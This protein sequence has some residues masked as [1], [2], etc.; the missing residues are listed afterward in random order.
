[1]KA[2]QGEF[3]PAAWA[4]ITGK[5]SDLV[6]LDF[7]GA[8]GK[9]TLKKLRLDPHVQTPSGGYHAYFKHPGFRVA[10]LNFKSK[11]DLGKKWP[12]LDI[13]ADGGY[14]I[15]CG[16]GQHGSYKRLRKPIPDKLY[17]LPS[18]LQRF[19][20]LVRKSLHSYEQPDKQRKQPRSK[21]VST[22]RLLK[23]ALQRA[24]HDLNSSKLALR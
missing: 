16:K 4:V 17:E 18:K 8:A 7:D 10:T 3:D 15:F 12:G 2:W 22:E 11:L 14:A 5:I 9:A 1:V 24:K 19:L 21:T 6:V 13:R 20:G 23:K